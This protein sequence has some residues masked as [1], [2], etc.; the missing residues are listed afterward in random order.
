MANP[1]AKRYPNCQIDPRAQIAPDVEIGS[2]SVIGGDVIIGQGTQIGAHVVIDEGARIGMHCRIF[3]GAV[4][5]VSPQDLKFAGEV[6]TTEIGNHVT[7]REY[8]TIHRGTS[9][10]GTTVVND[11]SL[12][13]AYV[14]VAHDCI[15]GRNVIISNGSNLAGHAVVDDHAVIGGMVAVHQF[16]QIG[17]HAMVAGASAIRKDIPPY[18]LTGRSPLSYVGVNHRGLSRRGFSQEII[19]HIQEIYRVVF[20]SG[21]N[22]TQALRAVESQFPPSTER[23][24]ILNFI[25]G[26]ERGIIRSYSFSQG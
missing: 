17:K 1:Y 15:V 13:M 3:P 25:R 12:I 24:D 4:I 23:E 20:L 10:R 18:V 5:S 22:V 16:S 9:H 7:I 19:R 21:L 2:F 11:H 6:T 14:H 26:S 8:A